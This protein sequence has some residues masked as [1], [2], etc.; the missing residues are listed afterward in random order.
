[1]SPRTCQ[2]AANKIRQPGCIFPPNGLYLLGQELQMAIERPIINKSRW[3]IAAIATTLLCALTG[4]IFAAWVHNGPQIL[5][6]L[7]TSALAWCF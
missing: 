4:I 5:M 2:F 1:M 3:L 7:G 6:S